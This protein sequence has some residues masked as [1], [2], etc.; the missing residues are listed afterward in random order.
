MIAAA[1]AREQ[2]APQ[3]GSRRQTEAGAG[4][5]LAAPSAHCGPF[6]PPHEPRALPPSVCGP[7]A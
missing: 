4:R 5:L 3:A 1:E 2:L 6:L 7:G